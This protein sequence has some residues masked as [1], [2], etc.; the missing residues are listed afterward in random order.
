MHLRIFV[1]I[2]SP[3]GHK[4]RSKN[5]VAA[6]LKQQNNSLDID[7]FNF[8]HASANENTSEVCQAKKGQYSTLMQKVIMIVPN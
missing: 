3:A 2:F 5:E 8:R 1:C 7:A 6:Y 4:F